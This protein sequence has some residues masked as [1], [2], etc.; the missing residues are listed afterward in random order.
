MPDPVTPPAPT[1]EQDIVEGL[2][3]DPQPPTPPVDNKPDN[4]GDNKPDNQDEKPDVAAVVQ[5]E[6]AKA[7]DQFK[8]D[9]NNTRSDLTRQQ[10][11]NEWYRSDDGKMFLQHKQYI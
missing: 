2:F 6:V 7:L 5:Q 11:L 8:R 1:P 9:L 4:K 3:A 10:Q